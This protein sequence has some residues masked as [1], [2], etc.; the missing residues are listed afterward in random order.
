MNVLGRRKMRGAVAAFGGVAVAALVLA[1]AAL[2][3]ADWAERGISDSAQYGENYDEAANDP[4]TRSHVFGPTPSGAPEGGIAIESG[5]G[6]GGGCDPTL[7]RPPS[8]GPA[9]PASSSEDDGSYSGC[10]WVRAWR[11]KYTLLGFL[12][13]R[14]NQRK[15]WC[16]SNRRITT[17]RVEAYMS[18]VDP[19]FYLREIYRSGWYYSYFSGIGNSG[20][21]SRRGARVEN[22]IFR[23]G[24]IGNTYP[25][26]KIYAHGDGSWNAYWGG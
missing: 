2:G 4:D 10:K 16:W 13:Y 19:N 18:D 15:Y 24:C 20:H 1:G 12:A 23:Y 14:W 22:C 7:C 11:N 17:V 25:W 3:E 26:V 8:T 6:G 5:G 9:A 21:Y